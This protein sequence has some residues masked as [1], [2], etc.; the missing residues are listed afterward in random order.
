MNCTHFRR[1][2]PPCFD[3]GALTLKEPVFR[4]GQAEILA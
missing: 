1:Y 2:Q 3:K 4:P